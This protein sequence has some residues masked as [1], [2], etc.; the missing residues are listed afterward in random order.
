MP[1]GTPS[2]LK[3]AFTIDEYVAL[4]VFKTELMGMVYDALSA[5]EARNVCEVTFFECTGGVFAN[6]LN[7]M[8]CEFVRST[9]SLSLCVFLY[10]STFSAF[11]SVSPSVSYPKYPTFT[12]NP[13][14]Q[15]AA[16]ARKRL[17][18][19]MPG[20][21]SIL[22][23][24]PTFWKMCLDMITAGSG[25]TFSYEIVSIT[26]NIGNCKV[27]TDVVE[28]EMLPKALGGSKVSNHDDGEDDETYTHGVGHPTLAE[29]VAG[30]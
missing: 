28:V 8:E 9:I 13:D 6:I 5:V 16:E 30:L 3:N 18:P 7:F 17:A 12:T 10:L 11:F 14:V 26:T 29:F 21:T 25:Y 24:F 19:P 27:V 22:V 15:V 2:G 1:P 4:T 20:S 23:N